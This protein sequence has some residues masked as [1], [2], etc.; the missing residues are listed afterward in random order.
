MKVLR[1]LT[2]SA[3]L[4]G[5]LFS[6]N[7]FASAPTYP[8]APSQ[9]MTPGSLCKSPIE[10][11]YPEKVPYCGRDVREETKAQ[12]IQN[13]VTRFG[14][15]ITPA[16]RSAF[17]IDHYLPL[18]M[19]GSNQMDNLWPQNKNVYVITDIIEEMSCLKMA[20]GKLRQADAV[21]LIKHVK[22][23]LSSAQ[24]VIRHLNAL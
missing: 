9:D 12:V 15:D 17:K 23:D 14:Y 3:M 7:V 11:R 1:L 5:F 24:D 19:G 4:L 6:V 18:C 13:Y 2:S 22:N 16:N 20:A 10:L 21:Q 8:L